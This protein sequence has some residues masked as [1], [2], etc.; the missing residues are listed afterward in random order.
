[1]TEPFETERSL[2]ATINRSIATTKSGTSEL[3]KQRREVIRILGKAGVKGNV[4]AE[5]A[6]VDP[7]EVS[8][9][10]REGE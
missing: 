10:L 4:I 6:G 2:L 8:R 9:A 3:I 7:M 1:M 5:M